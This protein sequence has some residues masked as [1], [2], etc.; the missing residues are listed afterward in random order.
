MIQRARENCQDLI[1][2]RYGQLKK[3]ERQVADLVLSNPQAII[4]MSIAE[5]A[6]AAEVSET[7]VFRL[8]KSLGYKG[9]YQFKIALASDIVTPL[10]N[11]HSEINAEDDRRATME[12]L[13]LGYKHSLQ[14]TIEV[15]SDEKITQAIELLSQSKTV[16]FM[17]NGGSY[18]LA[19]DAY[20]KFVRNGIQGSV[21]CDPHWLSMYLALASPEDLCLMISFSGRNRELLK[22]AR[23]ARERGLPI[24]LITANPSSPLAKIADL[25]L[26]AA[27]RE[28]EYR[29]EAMEARLSCLFLIDTLYVLLATQ[30]PE[31]EARVIKNIEKIRRDIAEHRNYKD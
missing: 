20:H 14:K 4:Q 31:S 18:A 30:D 16:F 26:I 22:I 25:S 3:R 23:T 15:N 8:A 24:L 12:K 19:L 17:G 27:G 1:R 11:V 6:R 2:L 13:Y 10:Q 7:T 29:S 5:V 28:Y 9:F 21:S